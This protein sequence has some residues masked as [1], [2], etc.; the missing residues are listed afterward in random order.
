MAGE[1][2]PPGRA[3][4]RG[5]DSLLRL[6]QWRAAGQAPAARGSAG[7]GGSSMRSVAA[8]APPRL[9][10]LPRLPGRRRWRLLLCPAAV[11]S[12][13]Y[14]GDPGPGHRFPTAGPV[15]PG[16]SPCRA[17]APGPEGPARAAR[18][19]PRA[20]APARRRPARPGPARR[21]RA[22][23]ARLPHPARRRAPPPAKPHGPGS[24]NLRTRIWLPFR[25]KKK[26]G[27]GIKKILR[28]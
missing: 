26:K 7:A 14:F 27:G 16:R 19:G 3:S 22:P 10:P 4:P 23:R 8:A 13:S 21:Q 17:L 11:T 1:S 24:K 28:L 6:W 12:S 20:A 18:R 15:P 9:V 25:L 2:G 5:R